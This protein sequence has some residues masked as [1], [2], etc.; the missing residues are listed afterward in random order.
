MYTKEFYIMNKKAI[1][2][3]LIPRLKRPIKKMRYQ[4][5]VLNNGLTTCEVK[6]VNPFKNTE[7]IICDA[8]IDLGAEVTV[9]CKT[10]YQQ[11]TIEEQYIIN[12]G[13]S[14]VN[15]DDD[16]A[17]FYPFHIYIPSNNWANESQHLLVRD[18]SQRREYNAIIGLDLLHR[19][20][21]FYDGISREAWIDV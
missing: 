16:N 4:L 20:R 11:F 10:L 8:L 7:A 3:P 12:D 14:T 18:L 1:H 21:L 2:L 17:V 15:G 6:F 9:I 5:K 19:C 13:V